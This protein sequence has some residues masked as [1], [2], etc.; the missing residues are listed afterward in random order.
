[1]A[2]LNGA[3]ARHRF[4]S[5][6]FFFLPFFPPFFFFCGVRCAVSSPVGIHI[7]PTPQSLPLPLRQVPVGGV[8]PT[9]VL[10]STGYGTRYGTEKTVEMIHI[11][12]D[13][14]SSTLP[15]NRLTHPPR[16]PLPPTPYPIVRPSKAPSTL[17]VPTKVPNLVGTYLST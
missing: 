1:M 8:S 3:S 17:P 12:F 5:L 14:S 4:R 2:A 6:L 9:R 13:T 7:C 15:C 16:Y 11:G 10:G